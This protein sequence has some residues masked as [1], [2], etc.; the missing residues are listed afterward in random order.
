MTTEHTAIGLIGAPVRRVED[1]A[2]ITGKGCFVEDIKLPGMLHLAFARSPYPHARITSID[3]S[4]AGAIPGVLAVVTGDDLPAHL[5]IPVAPMV[6]GMKVPPNPL[7]ARGAVHAVGTPIAAVVAESRA[8]AED[9]AGAVAVEYDPLPAVVSAEKALEPGAPLAREELDSNVCY[10]ATKKGGDVERAFAEA[11]HVVRM[12]I[13]SPRLVAL[14]LEPRG[15]VARPEPTG[16]LTVWL[17]T[18]SPHRVRPDL[19]AA[20]GFPEHRIRIVAPDVGG[21]FGS[22]GLLYREDALACHLALELRRPVKWI[23]TR[24]E[25]FVTTNQGRDQVMTSELALKRDGTMLGLKVRVVGN[26]GAYLNSLSAI[27]PLRMMAMAPGCYRIRNCQVEV[28]AVFTNTV[29]TGP[30]RG[31][32]RP[33][34][35]LNIERLVDKAARDLGIDRIEIR[36]KNFI[37]PEEFPYRTGVNVEYDSGDYEKSLAEALRL[38]G[39]EN[40]L[41]YR[42]EARRRGELVGVGL[43]TFVEPSGGAGFE[44]ATVRVERTGEITVLTGSSSHGQGHETVF[45]QV[46]AEKMRVSM[47]HVVVRHGDTFAVQ[48]GV[49]TFGS[50][51]AILGGGALALATDRVVEKA[52]R[53]AAHLMEAA[54]DDIVQADGGFAVAGVP[55]R[56]VTWR[57]VAAAA[58]GGNL[59]RGMEPGLH[60]TVFFDP[61]REAW[62]FGA[63]LAVVRIDRDTGALTIEK[64]VLVDDCGVVLNPLIVNGQIHGGVAQGLGEALCEQMLFGENGEVLTGSLMHYAAPRAADIPELTLG[65]TVTPNPFNPLGVKGVGEAGCNGAPPAVANAVMD[66]LA[67]LGID[68]IDMPY[69]APR[70]WAAIQEATRK[71]GTERT[72]HRS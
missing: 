19:A 12:R 51:S 8:A 40:L 9:A 66:A 41:R 24:S 69:T 31:A 54:A 55:G 45:A 30:Y 53:I 60:E 22:K 23:A 6:P 39:Y 72:P 17:S 34:S 20:I 29:P 42:D 18:Q 67:P 62:G 61:R 52:R 28:V 32:G 14:A 38:S 16:D 11:E 27:P 43:S 68:H 44:S 15:V 58:H 7:L 50:R 25:D 3:T 46:V 13:A 36:R 70:L 37:R 5:H 2:L 26:L 47:E 63:H 21:G 10:V 57:Q 48:Q 71:G 4:A 59:P 65:E 35:V 49:G 1:A 33:E 64:L 56:T